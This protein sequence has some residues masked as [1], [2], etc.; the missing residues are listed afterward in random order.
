[1][2]NNTSRC[3]KVRRQKKGED[4]WTWMD[5]NLDLGERK[6]GKRFFGRRGYVYGD[7]DYNIKKSC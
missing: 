1:M 6:W 4:G 3:T 7:I 2:F 5:M